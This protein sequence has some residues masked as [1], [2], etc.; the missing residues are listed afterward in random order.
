MQK[1]NFIEEDL[2]IEIC[3]LLRT[4][5]YFIEFSEILYN[6]TRFDNRTVLGSFHEVSWRR[7][8]PSKRTALTLPLSICATQTVHWCWWEYV[9]VSYLWCGNNRKWRRIR[10]GWCAGVRTCVCVILV[11]RY[12]LI[13]T[14][15][16]HMAENNN[17]TIIL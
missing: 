8:Q 13:S 9:N 2:Q 7:T 4:L 12:N 11:G 16:D 5:W 10:I 14:C 1:I 15:A 3:M 6:E 17:K